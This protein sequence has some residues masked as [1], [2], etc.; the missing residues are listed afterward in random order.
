MSPEWKLIV[1][2]ILAIPQFALALIAISRGER[3]RGEGEKWSLKG[4]L[5]EAAAAERTMNNWIIGGL[6]AACG[7]IGTLLLFLR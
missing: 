5:Q 4:K 7:G 6:L 2:I 1:A 3:Y